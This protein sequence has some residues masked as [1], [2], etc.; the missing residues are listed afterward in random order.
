[1]IR[2]HLGSAHPLAPALDDFLTDL[3]NGNTSAHTIRAYRG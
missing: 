2:E 3:R 1:V